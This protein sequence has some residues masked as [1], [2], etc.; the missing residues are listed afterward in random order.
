MPLDFGSEVPHLASM[1]SPFA[2]IRGFI[3]QV[4]IIAWRLVDAL[5]GILG[6][7][8]ALLDAI[9]TFE[10]PGRVDGAL[11]DQRVDALE[12]KIQDLTL[13]VSEGVQ[14]VQRSEYRVRHIVQGAKRE[15]AEA[16]FEHPGVEAEARELR[17]I[18]GDPIEESQLPPVSE[19]VEDAARLPSPIPGVSLATFRRSRLRR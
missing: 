6:T 1:W 18:D 14:R 8:R 17:E 12:V 4:L 15:L 19:V 2:V 11:E 3:T 9:N 7:M 10:W 5:E 13:A 16:G